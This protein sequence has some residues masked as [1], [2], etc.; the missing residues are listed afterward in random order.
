MKKNVASQLIVAQLINKSDGSP[1][2]SGTTDVYVSGNGGAQTAA[3]GS[4]SSSHLGNGAWAYWP[5]AAE[6]NYD[7]VAFTF[8]NSAALNVTV[9]VYP[10]Y[11]QSGDT[12]SRAGAPAGASLAADIAAILAAT[13][14]A[15]GIRTAV[16]LAS[17]NLDTQLLSLLNLDATIS[18]RA[19]AVNLATVAG[20]IDTEISDIQSRLPAALISGRIDATIGAMQ[21]NTLNASALASDA[22]AEIQSGLATSSDV[23]PG[24]TTAMTESY[25]ADGSA[26]TPAQALHMIWSL[27]AERSIA[28]T[29][30]TAKKLDGST[31]AMTFT[32]DSATTPTTQTRAT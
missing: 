17:A 20:Y 24:W 7:H 5:T 3:A 2:T 9:Q 22:V 4:P 11:P 16:G 28:S 23:D 25:A 14:N 8:V 18:S 19:S 10:S 6:T 31:T 13:L 26:M 15:A 21:A 1:V 27:L 29:T 32:L 12:F 30:L